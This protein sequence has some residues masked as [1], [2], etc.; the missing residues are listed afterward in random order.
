MYVDIEEKDYDQYIYRI[1]P[2]D[3]FIELF[4]KKENTQINPNSWEDTFEHYS[5]KS[6]F[7]LSDGAEIILDTHERLSGQRWTTTK[8]SVAM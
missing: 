5:L 3:R 6:K 7:K 8:A 2:Y 1:I 4:E